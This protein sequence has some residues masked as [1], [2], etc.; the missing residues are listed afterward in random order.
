[1][2]LSVYEGGLK[3]DEIGM[4]L[5]GMFLKKEGSPR[6]F[7]GRGDILRNESK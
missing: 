4:F 7:E 1:M 3:K 2:D 6:Y 5:I